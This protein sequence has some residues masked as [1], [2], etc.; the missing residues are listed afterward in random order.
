MSTNSSLYF[1]D[2]ESKKNL[3]EKTAPFGTFTSKDGG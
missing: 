3:T 2:V 1:L